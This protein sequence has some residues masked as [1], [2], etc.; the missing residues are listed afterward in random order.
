MIPYGGTF[1]VFSD[2]ARNSLRMAA[3]MGARSIFVLTHDSIGLGEDGPT[4]QPIEHVASLRLMP[5]MHVWRPCDAVETAAAWR[6]AIERDAG[7]T[8]LVLTRQDLPHMARTADQIAAIQ[9]GGYVLYNGDA[10]P[11]L[12]FIATGSEVQLALGAAQALEAEGAAVRVV[13][14]PCVE[15]FEAQPGD[16]RAHVLPPGGARLVVEAGAT[17]GWWRYAG[18]RGGVVGIDRFGHSAPAKDLFEHF[19]FTVPAVV[20]AARRLFVS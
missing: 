1:L 12:T 10:E 2:Y 13:C 19:G 18:D 11:A 14:M 5:N 17:G 8:S 4:H 16:Y 6:A 3:L 20:A 7:P 9:R 15:A